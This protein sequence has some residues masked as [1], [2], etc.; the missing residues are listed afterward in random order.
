[1]CAEPP[2]VDNDEID[3]LHPFKN[4][5]MAKS[6]FL[7]KKIKNGISQIVEYATFAS[8]ILLALLMIGS[9]LAYIYACYVD[10]YTIKV[11]KCIAFASLLFFGLGIIL[12]KTRNLVTS[13][14]LFAMGLGIYRAFMAARIYIPKSDTNLVVL[15]LFLLGV[16]V[17][18]SGYK[19]V[20]GKSR[21]R[22]SM[23][24]TTIILLLF[25]IIF[26][27][28]MIRVGLDYKTVCRTYPMTIL[29][30]LMYVIFILILDTKELR[31]RDWIEVH[32]NTLS[33][34][35]RT[36][37]FDY[38]AKMAT[39]SA[40]LLNTWNGE[41]KGWKALDDGGPAEYELRI[42]FING[43]GK[44]YIIAQI[45]KDYDGFFIT[46]SDHYDGTIIQASRMSVSGVEYEGN[47]FRII[48]KDGTFTQFEL[49]EEFE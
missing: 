31:S 48:A 46:I 47:E 49:V 28:Y 19:Y 13:V 43:N 26:V 20:T 34:M 35:R 12:D 21:S 6:E 41:R 5:E 22:V 36:Y 37:F 39:E 27:T 38:K 32:S 2:A 3:S 11:Y 7:S 30:S 45:W 15:V 10:S 16:N 24:I 8:C 25:N 40:E 23:K 14:G 29:T 4:R 44:S 42:P 9:A 17:A 18:I 1:M 33:R